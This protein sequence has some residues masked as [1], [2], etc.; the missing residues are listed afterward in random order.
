MV[1]DIAGYTITR[2][3]GDDQKTK[4]LEIVDAKGVRPYEGSAAQTWLNKVFGKKGTFINPF[5]LMSLPKK[6]QIAHIVKALPIDLPFARQRLLAIGHGDLDPTMEIH[7][8]EGVFSLIKKMDQNYREDRLQLG[9]KK[10]IADAAWKAAAGALPSDYDEN[11][12]PPVAPPAQQDLYDKRAAIVSRNQKRDML[13]RQLASNDREVR[14]M[15]EDLARLRNEGE[16]MKSELQ[17]IGSTLEETADLD[18]K[19]ADHRKLMSEY[20][21]ALENHGD[22]KKRRRER[23]E[24]YAEW[25]DLDARHSDL[26]GRVKALAKLPAD[27]FA[28]SE[29]PIPGMFIEDDTIMLPNENG[30]LRPA[31][32]FGDAALLDLYIALAMTLAP[33]PVIL[34][35]GLERCGPKR[36][37]EIYDRIRAKDFQLIGTR[38]T[39]G[40]LKVV[41]V[42]MGDR[43]EDLPVQMSMPE[44]AEDEPEFDFDM[45]EI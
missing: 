35:D 33:I 29:L 32:E 15:E 5:E 1:L 6:E 21:V 34:A 45:P 12:P 2:V 14:R 39:E 41:R 27:L 24:K 25:Q 18:A 13:T 8:A 43:E 19:I 40:P 36:S 20:Q 9:R 23:D 17:Q 3:A 38:V 11:C 44:T 30:E 26:D 31:E 42:N 7:D 28:R 37:Q 16:R 10:D 4:F 22:L